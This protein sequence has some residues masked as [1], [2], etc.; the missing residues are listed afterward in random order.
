MAVERSLIRGL[1]NDFI[2]V[3]GRIQPYRPTIE[4]VVR[5]CDRREGVGGDELLVIEPPRAD[6]VEIFRPD[7]S[8]QKK[9]TITII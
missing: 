8:N 4:E 7:L 3:D 5:I 2:V 1:C 6:S 9:H